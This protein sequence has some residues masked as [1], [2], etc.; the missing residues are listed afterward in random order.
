MA[1]IV[2]VK[3]LFFSSAELWRFCRTLEIFWW[4]GSRPKCGAPV[5]PWSRGGGDVARSG[6]KNG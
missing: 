6:E 5:E 4:P 3:C 1:D 2:S